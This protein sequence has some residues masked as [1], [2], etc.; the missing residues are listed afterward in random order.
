M[1]NEPPLR[2]RRVQR[3][4]RALRRL[5]SQYY[6]IP[7]WPKLLVAV[8][9]G[10]LAGLMVYAYAAAGRVIADDI[11]QVHLL[12][13]DRPAVEQLDPTL[14]GEQRRFGFDQPKARSVVGQLESKPGRSGHEKLRLLLGLAVLLFVAECLRHLIHFIGH[15]RQIYVGQA[16]VFRL[17][18]HLHAKLMQLPLS[19]HDRHSPGRLLT[20]L[21]SDLQVVRIQSTNLIRSVPANLLAMIVGVVIVLVLDAKLAVLVLLAL[22]TYAVVYRWFGKRLRVVNGNLRER[23][24]LLNAHIANR[25]SNFLL[26]KSFVRETG[27]AVDFLRQARPIVENNLAASFLNTSFAAVCGIITGLSMTA[28]L[29]LGVLR[30]RDG[31]MTLGQL[32]MFYTSAGYLFRPTATLTQLAGAT[33]RLRTVAGRIMAVLDEP[34][35]PKDPVHP[36]PV[37]E[38]ACQLRF[39]HVT[40]DYGDKRPPALKDVS[41]TLPAGKRLCVMGASGSGKTTLAKLVC[42]FYEATE[43]AVYFGG[44]DV[45]RFRVADLK[46]LVGYVAQEPVIFSGTISD[47][48]SYGSADTPHAAVTAAARYAQIHDF[49]ELLPHRYR[50]LTYERGLTLSGGQK[51]RVSLARALAYDPQVLVLDDCTSALDAHTEAQLID[52]FTDSLAD[53]TVVLITHRSSIAMACDLVLMLDEGRVAE[54]GPPQELLGQD[55]PFAELVREQGRGLK[56]SKSA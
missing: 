5:V 10:S 53:R 43:G 19:Y 50:T 54:L 29:W 52:A 33:H 38:Q 22:P 14:P 45:R 11:V 48:I 26:V 31:Q 15:E 41:F 39:E 46:R 56:L 47:N 7:H 2:P 18:C 49:I 17:R 1:I 37:P 4:T 3:D 27:E 35:T 55:G 12:A 23:E 9:M 34:I 32:L 42:R 51:Q 40:M 21:F 20:H 44:V 25:V 16:A 6:L 28:V 24:G 8:L 36:L 13:A 30:V